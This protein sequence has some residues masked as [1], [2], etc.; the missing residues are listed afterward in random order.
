[1]IEEQSL[2]NATSRLMAGTIWNS[3]VLVLRYLGV[4]SGLLAFVALVL[5]VS[6]PARHARETQA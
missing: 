6:L 4:G 3:V 2:E 1:M 5:L